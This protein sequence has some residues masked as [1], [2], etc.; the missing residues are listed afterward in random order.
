MIKTVGSI[1]HQ[2][3]ANKIAID[4]KLDANSGC[5]PFLL[6]QPNRIDLVDQFSIRELMSQMGAVLMNNPS[7]DNVSVM[8]ANFS[9]R[10]KPVA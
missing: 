3:S 8:S 4:L 9:G 6:L 2:N 5:K 1:L 7:S 10:K